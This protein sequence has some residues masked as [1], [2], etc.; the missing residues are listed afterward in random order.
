[1]RGLHEASLRIPVDNSVTGF[2]NIRI[3]AFLKRGLTTFDPPQYLLG[4]EAANI[5]LR[6]PTERKTCADPTGPQT[7]TLRGGLLRASIGPPHP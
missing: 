6:L 1:M 4:C 5:V 3:S 7:I 2:D